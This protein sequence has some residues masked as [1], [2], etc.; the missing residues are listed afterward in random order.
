MTGIIAHIASLSYGMIPDYSQI[1]V[2]R[3]F[4][5]NKNNETFR[6]SFSPKRFDAV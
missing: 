1:R 4:T 6:A 5:T 3:S 2:W